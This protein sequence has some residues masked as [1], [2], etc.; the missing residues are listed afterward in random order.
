[1]FRLTASILAA[2]LFPAAV[3]AQLSETAGWA[4]HVS[5]QYRL[6]PN[7]TY[8]TAN[9]WESKLDLYLRRDVT[10]PNATLIYIH[11]GGWVGGS[12]EG[13]ALTFVPYLEMGWNVVNVEYRLGRVALA[14][15]AVEDCLCA[16]RWIAAHAKDYDIDT[17]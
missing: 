8:P 14:P 10:G 3:P 12:K 13:A 17:G 9:N 2:L 6:V 7:V 15:A 4:A 1:M 11:G 5:N 16:L